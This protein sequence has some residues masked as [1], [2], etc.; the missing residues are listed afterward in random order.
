MV[1]CSLRHNPPPPLHTHTHTQKKGH[2]Q[3]E[4]QGPAVDE[5]DGAGG[6]QAEG[7]HGEED[8]TGVSSVSIA[9][10]GAHLGVHLSIYT[11]ARMPLFQNHVFRRRRVVTNFVPIGSL[12]CLVFQR[13]N[14]H[15]ALRTVCL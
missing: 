6:P 7:R 10:L 11:H 5:Q 12:L 8:F 1:R 2:A 3:K 13:P 14:Q 15:P 9:H 4:Q